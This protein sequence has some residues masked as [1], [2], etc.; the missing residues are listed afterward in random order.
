MEP[1]LAFTLS[2]ME[3]ALA[4]VMEC[5]V[6]IFDLVKALEFNVNPL[7]KVIV[8]VFGFKFHYWQWEYIFGIHQCHHYV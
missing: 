7:L 3:L 2:L 4:L 6:S 8:L 5:Q 1:T